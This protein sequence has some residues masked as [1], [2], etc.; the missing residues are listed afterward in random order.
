MA[1][2]AY[3]VV[4]AAAPNVRLS[5]TDTL[6]VGATATGGVV[7]TSRPERGANAAS[8]A[9]EKSGLTAAEKATALK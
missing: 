2:V 4:V 6:V 5:T 3:F 8:G 7:R 9:L 1:S